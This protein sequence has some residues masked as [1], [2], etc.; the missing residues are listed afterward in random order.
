MVR[1]VHSAVHLP[2]W[3][4]AAVEALVEVV[5]VECQVPSSASVGC[6]TDLELVKGNH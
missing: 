6:E 4:L 1:A 2:P 3:G 5:V